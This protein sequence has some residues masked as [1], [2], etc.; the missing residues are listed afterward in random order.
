MEEG[1]EEAIPDRADEFFFSLT[2]INNPCGL[3]GALKKPLLTRKPS[4][5]LRPY[6]LHFPL[7][8]P[9]ALL[10]SFAQGFQL[11]KCSRMR[12]LKMLVS[13]L[14][15]LLLLHWTFMSWTCAGIF[16]AEGIIFLYHESLQ[17]Q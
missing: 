10:V 13:C 17:F 8:V 5:P 1:K 4:A 9:Q 15:H 2:I 3:E 7:M 11:G 6:P 16:R 14:L 12:L